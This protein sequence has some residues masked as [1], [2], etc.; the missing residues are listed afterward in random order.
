MT[1]IAFD[2]KML[3]ADKQLTEGNTKQTVTKIWRTEIGLMAICGDYLK[4]LEIKSWILQV[5][6]VELYPLYDE[7][8]EGTEVLV[9]NNNKIE[10]YGKSPYPKTIEDERFAM[11]SGKSFAL[12]AMHLN[13]NAQQAVQTACDFD[14]YC[15][16]GV[17]TL[18]LDP[19][20]RVEQPI[21]QYKATVTTPLAKEVIR[22]LRLAIGHPDLTNAEF[23]QLS[24]L[25]NLY[26][27]N[28]NP[29]ILNDKQVEYVQTV[30]NKY[31]AIK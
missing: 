16:M 27:A 25:M 3:A 1:I 30:Y 14:I 20:L 17:D 9:V 7:E 13:C 4:A 21:P 2:G 5:M 28:K 19:T 18:F 12:A 15:G 31:Y 11:G 24:T 6:P 29:H 22:R 10:V 26:N 8:H 23:S